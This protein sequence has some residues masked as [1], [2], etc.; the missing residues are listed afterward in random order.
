VRFERSNGFVD[1]DLKTFWCRS[2]DEPDRPEGEVQAS[3][4]SYAAREWVELFWHECGSFD[5][6]RVRV[7]DDSGMRCVYDV[8]IEVVP[9]FS[10][11]DVSTDDNGEP[12][13]ADELRRQY[14]AAVDEARAR[15]AAR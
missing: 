9:H 15:K 6:I 7:R 3:N 13:S 4:A 14:E 8:H 1:A 5:E 12:L 2:D 10:T 11:M